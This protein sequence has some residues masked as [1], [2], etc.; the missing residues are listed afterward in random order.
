MAERA[1]ARIRPAPG[2]HGFTLLEILAVVI[3]ISIVV[4]FASLSLGARAQ[5]ERL[6]NEA[7]RLNQLMQSAAEEAVV[8]G[9]ELGL[10]VA[11]DG[12]RFYHL[13]EKRWTP[14]TD[15][16]LRERRL[17]D[18]IQIQLALDGDQNFEMLKVEKKENESVPQI[19]FLSSG[20]LTPFVL[21]LR[22]GRLPV[23]YRAEGRIT[24]GIE[25]KRVGNS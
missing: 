17:P 14:Y 15:G 13:E 16:P 5:D 8:Q 10:L 6:A 18:G 23:H 11:A 12:Y 22:S 7:L 4:S 9:E 3:I 21:E 2:Q 1:K 25:M 19:L 24:G 20:E